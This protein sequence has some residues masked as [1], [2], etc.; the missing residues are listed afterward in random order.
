MARPAGA[1]R[2]HVSACRQH[3][4]RSCRLGK[5]MRASGEVPAVDAPEGRLGDLKRRAACSM[6]PCAPPMDRTA[7]ALVLCR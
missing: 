1:I 3:E 5:L 4:A 6:R 7:R 2:R